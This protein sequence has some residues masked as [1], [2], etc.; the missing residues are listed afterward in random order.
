MAERSETLASLSRICPSRRSG[1]KTSSGAPGLG[2]RPLRPRGR[3]HARYCRG[4]LFGQKICK[5]VDA[6]ANL[7]GGAL[8]LRARGPRVGFGS[9]LSGVGQ[10]GITTCRS[11]SPTAGYCGGQ[12]LGGRM[13]HLGGLA[14]PLQVA[15]SAIL[16][17]T[18]VVPVASRVSFVSH[19]PLLRTCRHGVPAATRHRT[20]RGR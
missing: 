15:A 6:G 12:C 19:L 8:G 11:N 3:R 1:L 2:C 7:D 17:T 18:L 14:E 5:R 10:R 16:A 9:S 13:A 20:H 4:S